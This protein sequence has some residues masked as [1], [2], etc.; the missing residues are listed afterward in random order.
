MLARPESSLVMAWRGQSKDQRP[1]ESELFIPN[2][3]HPSDDDCKFI[4]ILASLILVSPHLHFPDCR[5]PYESPEW[6]GRYWHGC[7]KRENWDCHLHHQ[8]WNP[9]FFEAVLLGDPFNFL[10]SWTA[11]KILKDV[12]SLAFCK[13]FFGNAFILGISHK[14]T[15]ATGILLFYLGCQSR[16]WSPPQIKMTSFVPVWPQKQLDRRLLI[17]LRQ[18]SRNDS[19]SNF[20][21]RC[22][23]EMILMALKK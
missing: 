2:R 7:H 4:N 21:H 5:R 3:P 17:L 14:I 9:F 23:V 10:S 1:L 20:G 6:S 12:P 15:G 16:I 22:K 13:A 18:E 11:V 8:S 19:K